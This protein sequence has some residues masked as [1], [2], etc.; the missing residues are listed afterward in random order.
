MKVDRLSLTID[1]MQT[2][3]LY[4]QATSALKSS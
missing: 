3:Q 2:M 1:Y 4:V